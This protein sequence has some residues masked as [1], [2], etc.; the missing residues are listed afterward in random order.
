MAT[1]EHGIASII[2][3][4]FLQLAHV[5]PF[6]QNYSFGQNVYTAP[7]KNNDTSLYLKDYNILPYNQHPPV[8]IK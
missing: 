3:S 6:L 7:S 4:S 1:L 8:I 2:N 5:K